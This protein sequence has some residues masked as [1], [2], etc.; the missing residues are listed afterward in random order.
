MCWRAM[1]C[2]FTAGE[3]GSRAAPFVCRRLPRALRD[4]PR[5]EARAVTFRL[6]GRAVWLTIRE[7]IEELQRTRPRRDESTY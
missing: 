6:K 1:S 5:A 4:R 7:A 2:S 3:R